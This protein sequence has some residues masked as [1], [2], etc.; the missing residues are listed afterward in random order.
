MTAS[1][2]NNYFKTKLCQFQINLENQD[3]SFITPHFKK[4]YN[5]SL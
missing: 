3:K 2:T 4:D 5:L 1:T